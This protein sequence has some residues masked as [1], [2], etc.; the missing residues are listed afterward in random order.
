[1][2]ISDLLVFKTVAQ[3]GGIS[4]AAAK[5][6]RVPSNITARVQKLEQELGTQLFVR[7]KNRLSTSAAGIQLLH[8]AEKILNLADQ[9]I[10]ELNAKSPNGT[11]KIGAMEAAATTHLAPILKKYHL[12][13]PDVDLVMRTAP[14][15]NLIS[16]VL[17]GELDVAF[18]ADPP[19]DER[20]SRQLAFKETLVLVSSLDYPRITQPTQLKADKPLLGFNPSCTYRKRL[21]AWVKTSERAFNVVEIASY[22]TLLNCAAAGMGVGLVP[23]SLIAL[24]PF[25]DTLKVHRLSRQWNQSKTYL[26]WRTGFNNIT[27]KAFANMVKD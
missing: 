9:A 20:L 15:G 18:V 4:K 23:E 21:E 17:Q 13:F 16:M 1:M 10:N 22:A 27:I 12:Q 2:E 14:T 24:Y 19:E 7:N 11:L 6:H 5:L 26:I 8:Y 25:P 3:E